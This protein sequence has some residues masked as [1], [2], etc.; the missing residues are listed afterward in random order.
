MALVL[1][2]ID[3]AGYGPMLG[4]LCVGMSVFRVERWQ[5]GTPAP[6]LWALLAPEVS[7]TA[8]GGGVPIADSKDLKRPN[9]SRGCHPLVYLERGV[10]AVA[11]VLGARPTDDVGLLDWLGAELDGHEC[12][13]GPAAGLPVAHTAEQVGIAANLVSSACVRAG[14][15]PLLLACRVVGE[16]EFNRIVLEE[17]SKSAATLRAIGEHLR[18]C[19]E[20][21][22]G[23]PLW[24]MCDRLGGRVEYGRVLE[25][26]LPG[27]GV[28][29]VEESAARSAYRLRL[30][31]GGVAGVT[32]RSEG[33]KAHL[34]VA[35]AS[36]IA[37]YVRELAMMRF[38]R[39]WS[40]LDPALKPTAGYVRDARRWLREAGG[41]LSREDRA[42]LV[43]RA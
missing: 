40:G 34:A 8:R 41:L 25:R 6:D 12:Y 7:R 23:E 29:V 22:G 2:G 21:W 4:P 3:E 43:R 39:H 18:L 36:M 10:L 17:R 14:V 31:G 1:A 42:R 30:A 11:R 27:T 5:T 28:E 38:N 13:G 26:L 20:R 24:V 15:T 37:K 35:L 16:E 19:G 32:F 9:D 33:E